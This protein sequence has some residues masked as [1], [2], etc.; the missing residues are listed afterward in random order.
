MR[1][2]YSRALKLLGSRYVFCVSKLLFN[3]TLFFTNEFPKQCFRINLPRCCLIKN[4]TN[5]FH[6]KL[7]GLSEDF[8]EVGVIKQ[9][10]THSLNK[11]RAL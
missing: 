7:A 3:L 1:K 4:T 11:V 8:F 6:G 2:H 5:F 10:V 9:R